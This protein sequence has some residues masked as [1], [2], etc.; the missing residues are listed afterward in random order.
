M[1]LW[2]FGKKK[3][4][5]SVETPRA[6]PAVPTHLK[7]FFIQREDKRNDTQITGDIRCTCG[8][9]TFVAKQSK[10]DDCIYRL[11]CDACGTDI[12][13]F[14]ARVHGWD[15]IVC[16]M[17]GEHL[18]LGDTTAKCEKCGGEHFHVTV[19]VEPTEKE[20]FIS[21]TEGELP[22]SEWVNAFTWFAAHLTCAECGC[23]QRDWAD[24]ET[25]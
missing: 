15:A 21:C 2:P 12:L 25:A 11:T 16:K 8:C 14:D 10:D 13:L 6:E 3:E 22:D 24:I 17:P 9:E 19:W 20:E 4:Q 23:K 5:M 7:P 1:R 18:Q